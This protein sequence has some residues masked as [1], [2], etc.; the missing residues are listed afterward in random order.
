MKRSALVSSVA[1]CFCL[2]LAAPALAADVQ[3]GSVNNSA[4]EKND[5][6]IPVWRQ[7]QIATAQPVTSKNIPFRPE[8]LLG[9]EVRNPQNEAL[10]SVENLVMSPATDKVAYLVIALDRS[11]G[12]DDISVPVPLE[13]FKITQ[14][15]NLL[16]LD[17]TRVVLE[18]APRVNP[19]SAD[20]ID[21][22]SQKV[23]SY[24]KARLSNKG[25]N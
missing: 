19:F 8:E 6:A 5:S 21:L 3:T 14:D 4:S 23:D 17:T 13:D 1:A 20:G 24:W 11:L 2:G 18:T 25:V 10:G 12:I 15:A 9:T 16:V 22:Q 7:R